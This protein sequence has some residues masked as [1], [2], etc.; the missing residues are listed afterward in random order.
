MS[1]SAPQDGAT[2]TRTIVDSPLGLLGRLP[3]ELRDKIYEYTIDDILELTIPPSFNDSLLVFFTRRLPHCLFLCHQIFDEAAKAYLHHTLLTILSASVP[4]PKNL[5]SQAATSMAFKN[6][7]S[8][9]FTEPQ[10]C[11]AHSSDSISPHAAEVCV[12]DIVQLCPILRDLTMTI[13]ANMLFTHS[14]TLPPGPPPSLRTMQ[15]VEEKMQFSQ[16]FKQKFFRKFE[17]D[18]LLNLQLTCNDAAKYPRGIGKDNRS[19]FEPFVKAFVLE[20]RK[21]K[22]PMA[23][24]I[25]ICPGAPGTYDA[26]WPELAWVKGDNITSY[27]YIDFFG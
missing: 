7:R 24:H 9:D 1:Q 16:L 25:K 4:G 26:N 12:H 2:N 13:S 17:H 22:N 6:L 15:E 21:K 10:D 8:L 20:A 3:L 23:L 11:Y 14:E 18:G 27:Y 19:L 5:L